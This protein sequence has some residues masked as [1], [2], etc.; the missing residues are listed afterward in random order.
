MIREYII[1]KKLGIGSYGTVYQVSHKKT[2]EIYVIK[3]IPLYDLSQEEISNVKL[4]AKILKTINSNYVVKYYDSFEENNHLNIVMEYCNG[5]DLGQYIDSNKEKNEKISEELI[6]LIFIKITLGLAAIHKL[7]ILHRDLK[8]LNIFLSKNLEIKIGDLGV[9]KILNNSGSFANTLIGT[10]YYLSPELCE[11]K[12]YNNKSDIWALGCILYELCTFKHPFSAKS[13]AGLIIKILKENPEPIGNEYSSELQNIL[14]NI[15]DKN[16][17]K[18]PSCFNL[19]TS[20][21]ILKKAKNYGLFSEIVKLY[22]E[23]P[24]FKLNY[25]NCNNKKRI[26]IYNK[27]RIREKSQNNKPNVHNKSKEQNNNIIYI[28]SD[29][30]KKNNI[31]INKNQIKYKKRFNSISIDNKNNNNSG[32][33]KE[34]EKNNNINNKKKI[35]SNLTPLNN[36]NIKHQNISN[37]IN[38]KN[39]SN[40]LFIKKFLNKSQDKNDIC[41]NNDNNG[42][43]TTTEQK[44]MFLIKKNGNDIIKSSKSARKLFID[45]SSNSKNQ[46]NKNETHSKR[47][48]KSIEN[49]FVFIKKKNIKLNSSQ[50]YIKR[51]DDIKINNN[52]NIENK[53][54]SKNDIQV[55][56][57]QLKNI[58]EKENQND[59]KSS[60]ENFEKELKKYKY[61]SDIKYKKENI[62]INGINTSNKI[63]LENDLIKLNTNDIL[64]CEEEYDNNKDNN[65]MNFVKNLNLYIPQHKINKQNIDRN[66]NISKNAYKTD[67]DINL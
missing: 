58:N 66:I 48:N 46:L 55:N 25:N 65:I 20:D 50:D 59:V 60:I 21:I 49:K 30:K 42:R 22:P 2:K 36:I 23:Y 17:E 12:P 7:K 39:I 44:K 63:S 61:S 8:T 26:L 3:Q 67:K 4:E 34:L 5:G 62:N 35:I 1:Q 27:N 33:N 43:Y 32:H 19:L 29:F 28:N 57:F 47:N 38:Y 52:I 18:R 6:W 45:L 10:P 14:N 54:E 9:A 40:N 16:M 53:E 24:E 56:G 37:K 13:Q 11:E 31:Y 51:N 64:N 41:K 15:F